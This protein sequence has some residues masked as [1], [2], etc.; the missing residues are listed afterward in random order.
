MIVVVYIN[1]IIEVFTS[2]HRDLLTAAYTLNFNDILPGLSI[3][4]ASIF[5]PKAKN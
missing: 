4:V 2:T 5:P 1:G 3:P